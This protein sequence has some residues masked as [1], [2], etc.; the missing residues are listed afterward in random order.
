Y[1]AGRPILPETL[2]AMPYGERRATV[3]AAINATGP[4]PATEI[5]NPADP[6]LAGAINAWAARTG[7][8]TAH[9]AILTALAREPDLQPSWRRVLAGMES[10]R[11]VVED[12]PGDRAGAGR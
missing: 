4:S 10:G 9:A 2:K 7:S 1:W 12:T 6:E 3:V 8:S 11:L 5:R